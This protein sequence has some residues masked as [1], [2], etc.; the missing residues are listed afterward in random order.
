[1]RAL[2]VRAWTPALSPTLFQFPPEAYGICVSPLPASCGTPN[3]PRGQQNAGLTDCRTSQTGRVTKCVPLGTIQGGW[4]GE[5]N[6]RTREVEEETRDLKRE[7]AGFNPSEG[8]YRQE[9]K[10]SISPPLDVGDMLPTLLLSLWNPPPPPFRGK[11]NFYGAKR[12]DVCL[13]RCHDVV[14]KQKIPPKWLKR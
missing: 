13:T 2:C 12:K 8:K 7:V 5:Q 6:G 9:R 3:P 14:Q 1:M 11:W 4:R 10:S